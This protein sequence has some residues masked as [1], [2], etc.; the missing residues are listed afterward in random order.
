MLLYD[1]TLHS[2]EKRGDEGFLT[3][4]NCSAIYHYEI[5]LKKR[6]S[7]ASIPAATSRVSEAKPSSWLSLGRGKQA[8]CV[9][10]EG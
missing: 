9:G 3:Q 6:L 4:S 1:Q 5:K 7:V 10:P 8:N 2:G